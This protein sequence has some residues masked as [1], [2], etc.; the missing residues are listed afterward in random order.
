M[1]NKLN[2]FWKWYNQMPEP[3]RFLFAIFILCSPIHIGIMTGHYIIGVIITTS[4]VFSKILTQNA[5]D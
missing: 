2:Q 5:N 3:W 1:K 4:I